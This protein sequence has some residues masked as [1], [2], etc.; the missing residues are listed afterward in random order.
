MMPRRDDHASVPPAADAPPSKTRRKHAMHELQDLGEALV[1]LDPPRLA[2]LGLPELQVPAENPITP[3]KVALGR[4]LFFDRRLS[5]NNTMSCAM[6]HVPEQGFTAHELATPVGMEGR[7]VRRNAPTVLNAGLQ[8][9]LPGVLDARRPRRR[10]V[11]AVP[12]AGTCL[13]GQ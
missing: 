11:G 4:K 5:P 13:D 8:K 1:A 9:R 7:S 3:D 12:R 10:D 6:C 2:A